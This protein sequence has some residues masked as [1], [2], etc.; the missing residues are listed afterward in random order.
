M[1]KTLLVHFL[2]EEAIAAETAAIQDIPS[3]QVMDLLAAQAVRPFHHAQRA[4][5][6]EPS[7][8][9]K[10]NLVRRSYDV[11]LCGFLLLYCIFLFLLVSFGFKALSTHIPSK[12]FA[13]AVS[14]PRAA[15]G[16]EQPHLSGLDPSMPVLLHCC[17]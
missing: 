1:A 12:Q 8:T 7:S 14:L 9:R 13:Q 6:Y 17:L 3:F 15:I 4:S 11:A 10:A 5:S 16:S 2:L